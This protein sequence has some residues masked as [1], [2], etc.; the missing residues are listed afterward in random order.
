MS[1]I[2]GHS[3]PAFEL[4]HVLGKKGINVLIL[5]SK[6]SGK[7]NLFHQ[8]LLRNEGLSVNCYRPFSSPIDFV[9]KTNIRFIEEILSWADII[10]AYD[11]FTLLFLCKFSH[12]NAK[13]IYSCNSNIKCGIY[14]LVNS[15]LLSFKNLIRLDYLANTFLPVGFFSRT[16]SLADKIICWSKFMQKKLKALGVLNTCIIPPGVNFERFRVK[17]NN[18]DRNFTFLYLG[19]LASARG[20][21]DLLKAFELVNRKWPSTKLIIAHTGLHLSEQSKFLNKIIGRR[22]RRNIEITG[23]VTNISEIINKANV[24]VLPFRTVLGYSQPPLTVLEALAH[25]RPV[26]TTSVGCLPELVQNGFNGFCIR[27]R[28]PYELAYAMLKMREIDLYYMS[29]NAEEYVR[30]NHN[31]Q[32]ISDLTIK[33]YNEVLKQVG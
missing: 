27:P 13:K 10:H 2:S 20:V 16:L 32:I 28:N 19:Y 9:R 26:I 15:G 14:E 22:S 24:A 6:L 29:R 21:A 7:Y 1:L 5:S 17:E 8:E 30:V 3:R 31:W 18:V 12:I 23:F 25:G 11:V 4:A 33:V